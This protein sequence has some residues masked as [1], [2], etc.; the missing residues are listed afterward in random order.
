MPF[1][2]AGVHQPRLP[3]FGQCSLLT[4]AMKLLHTV[5]SSLPLAAH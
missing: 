1:N 2:T 3:L 5:A 4:L